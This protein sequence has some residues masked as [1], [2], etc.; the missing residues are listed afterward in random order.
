[1]KKKIKDLTIKDVSKICKKYKS[2]SNKCPLYENYACLNKRC[3]S[4]LLKEVLL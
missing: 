4:G 1:M 2:C 3:R